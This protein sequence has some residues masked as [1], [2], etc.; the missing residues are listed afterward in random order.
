MGGRRVLSEGFDF[1]GPEAAADA[2]QPCTADL[3]AANSRWEYENLP[4]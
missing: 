2:G 4:Y 1:N 3:L